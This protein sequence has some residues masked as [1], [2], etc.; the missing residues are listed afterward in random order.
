[1]AAASINTQSL[2][3]QFKPVQ[4]E[5]TVA[6]QN[7][8]ANFQQIARNN[9]RR[10]L[11]RLNTTFRKIRTDDGRLYFTNE[12]TNATKWDLPTGATVVEDVD[13]MPSLED[14]YRQKKYAEAVGFHPRR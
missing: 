1:M 9:L 5:Q 7:R 3:S 6:Y 12:H 13:E 14:W 2:R 8:C 4:S 10:R 11:Q